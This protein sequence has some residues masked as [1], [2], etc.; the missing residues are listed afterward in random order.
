MPVSPAL[1]R[2][3]RRTTYSARGVSVRIGRRSAQMD[4]LLAGMAA[5]AGGFVTAWNPLSKRMPDGWNRRMQRALIAHVRRL[6]ALAGLGAGNG[7]FEEHLFIAADPRRLLVL[8][9]RFRQLGV[10]VVGRS[11]PARLVLLTWP[12]LAAVA[13]PSNR[14]ERALPTLYLLRTRAVAATMLALRCEQSRRVK[15]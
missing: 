5:R 3:Y 13:N 4:A 9:R 1:L 12:G 15:P 10:V 8:A 2:A 11:R 6:P 7:W 14:F